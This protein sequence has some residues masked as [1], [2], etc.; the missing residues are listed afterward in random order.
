M[1]TQASQRNW[2]RIAVAVVILIVA[3]AISVSIRQSTRVESYTKADGAAAGLHATIDYDTNTGKSP[4]FD[5]N[6][7]MFNDTG[8]QISAIRPDKEGRVN[9]ALPEGNYNM[10]VG[11]QFGND[12]LFPQ[13]PLALKDGQALELKLH[14]K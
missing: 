8:Q 12:K 7:Y 10:I 3:I 1:H 4:S 6:V 14:Y 2:I 5:F 13:E 11:K 9:M